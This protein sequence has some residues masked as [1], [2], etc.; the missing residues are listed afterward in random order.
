VLFEPNVLSKCHQIV[1][2]EMN[3]CKFINKKS[4]Q[5]ILAIGKLLQLQI[6]MEVYNKMNVINMIYRIL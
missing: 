2:I 4:T 1:K 3:I 5:K 6:A